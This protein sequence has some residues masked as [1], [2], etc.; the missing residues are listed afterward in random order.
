MTLD[1]KI[2]CQVKYAYD[3]LN[4]PYD[5]LENGHFI[6]FVHRKIKKLLS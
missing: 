4:I 2:L 3:N 1:Y 6:S 5:I